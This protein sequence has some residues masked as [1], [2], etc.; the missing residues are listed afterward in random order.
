MVE[1]K[2]EY[3]V[4]LLLSSHRYI[5]EVGLGLELKPFLTSKKQPAIIDTGCANTLV[6]LDLAKQHGKR[7]AAEYSAGCKRIGKLEFWL[8]TR[9][10]RVVFFGNFRQ[11]QL[12][13]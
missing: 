3:S 13:L 6:D 9:H 2:F 11:V 8:K 1:H 7:L 12:L 10:A 4:S 5:C